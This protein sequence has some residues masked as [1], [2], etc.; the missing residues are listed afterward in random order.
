MDKATPTPWF[1]HDF[2]G[3]AAC[4]QDSTGARPC[5]VTISCDDPATIT[6]AVMDR[7]LTGTMEEARANAALIMCAVNSHAALVSALEAMEVATRH[8]RYDADK[9]IA[10]AE[11]RQQTRAALAAAKGE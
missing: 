7:G 4:D 9:D 3:I 5:D 2:S 1:V 8:I 10:F 11:A 6:V